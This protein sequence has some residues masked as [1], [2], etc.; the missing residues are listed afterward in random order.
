[1]SARAEQLVR[2]PIAFERVGPIV[3]CKVERLTVVT[4]RGLLTR[5]DTL[6]SVPGTTVY[7][8]GE[9]RKENLGDIVE[10]EG[11]RNLVK[12]LS[13]INAHETPVCDVQTARVD[14]TPARSIFR[15]LA[16][17]VSVSKHSPE[18]LVRISKEQNLKHPLFSLTDEGAVELGVALEPEEGV[19]EDWRRMLL[20]ALMVVGPDQIIHHIEHV[21]DQA[22]EPDYVAASAA[23]EELVPL[24]E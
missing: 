23:I 14:G 17:V 18:E 13:I 21:M 9:V 22:K 8:G 3:D 15:K 16:T 19:S 1:M 10:G 5:G 11:S 2:L 24:T 7:P 20:R 4:A 12:L 6:P